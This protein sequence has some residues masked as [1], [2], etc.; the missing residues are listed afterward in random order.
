MK[1][2]VILAAFLAFEAPSQAQIQCKAQGIKL[3]SYDSTDELIYTIKTCIP[4]GAGLNASCRSEFLRRGDTGIT[5]YHAGDGVPEVTFVLKNG[6]LK[7]FRSSSNL[8]GSNP[9]FSTMILK[10]EGL[11]KS[12]DLLKALNF[13]IVKNGCKWN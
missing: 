8:G 9:V 10:A 3:G 2:L 4:N 5:F 1:F 7:G 13:V 11:P 12:M 6:T